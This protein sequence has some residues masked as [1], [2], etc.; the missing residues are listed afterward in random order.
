V[1][2]LTNGPFAHTVEGVGRKMSG[3]SIVFAVQRRKRI[4]VEFL[5]GV[6]SVDEEWRNGFHVRGMCLFEY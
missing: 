5:M 6:L 1:C 2:D 3:R 4:V